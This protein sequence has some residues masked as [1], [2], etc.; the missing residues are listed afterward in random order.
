MFLHFTFQTGG[1]FC[2]VKPAP[3][4][5]MLDWVNYAQSTLSE[6]YFG[7]PHRQTDGLLRTYD[8][9]IPRVPDYTAIPKRIDKINVDP[10]VGDD[11]MLAIDSTG[12]KVANRGEWMRNKWK[13]R[14]GFLKITDERPHDALRL[15][16]LV[17]QALHHG[18]ASKVLADA[19]YDSKNN[20]TYNN[21]IV[22]GIKV[23]NNSSFKSG[24]CYPQKMS[25]IS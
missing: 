7:S 4:T 8:N 9:T 14:R 23:R 20:F 10:E 19:A 2:D 11:I 17:D 18:R 21:D 24:G 12:I 13:K 25:V 15:P 5:L 16:S 3:S 6:S 22:P 1:Y